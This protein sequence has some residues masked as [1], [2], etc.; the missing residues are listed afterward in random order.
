[1]AQALIHSQSVP[2][3]RRGGRNPS[4]IVLPKA[5][6]LA[7]RTALISGLAL[8]AQFAAPVAFAQTAPSAPAS[9][10]RHYAVPAGPLHSVL[11]SFA[12]SAGLELSVDAHLLQGRTSSGLSGSFTVEQGFAELLR[13]QGLQAVRQANGSYTL[14]KQS[15]PVASGHD[16]SSHDAALAVVTVVGQNANQQDRPRAYAGGQVARGARLG[17][18]GDVSVMDAPFN[19]T[20]YT[21]KL[22]EDQQSKTVNDVLRNDPSVRMTTSDGHNAENI[23]IRGFDVNSSEL[24]FNGMYGMLPGAHTPTD[25]LERVEVFKGPSAMLSGIAPSGAVG[26]V[27]NLVPKRAADEPLTRLTTSYVSASTLG[28]AL[29]VGRRFGED[30]QIGVRVNASSSYG[31]S[32]LEDQDKRERFGSLGLD[33]RGKGWKLEFDAYSA[34]QNQSNGSPLMVGFGTLGHV[35]DAPDPRTNALRGTWAK[36]QSEGMAVRGELDLSRQW[37]L[38]AALG[39]ARYSYDGYLNGTRVVVL[40]DDGSARGQTYNQ[41]GYTHSISTEFGLRGNFE[42]GVVGHKLGISFSSLQTRNGSASV[43]SS[44]SYKTNIYDPTDALLAAEHGATLQTANNRY[45]GVSLSDT[46]SMLDDALL[47]TLGARAQNVKQLQA[48]PVAYDEDALTPVV[49]IVVK[50]WGPSLSLYA[51]YIEG[52]SPGAT[53]GSTY[54]N[55]GETLAPYKTRQSEAGVKWEW[56]SFTN[57]FSLFRIEKPS[58]ISID[59]GAKLPTLAVDGKQRHTGLEWNVFGEIAPQVRLLGGIAYTKAEQLR[60]SVAANDGKDAPGVPRWAANLGTEW[61]TPWIPALTLSTRLIYTGSQYLDAAN[62]LEIPSW[63]RWD[64]GANYAQRVYGKPFTLRAAVE[65]VTD[66]RYWA[67][68]FNDGFATQGAPR[69]YKL[70]ASLDF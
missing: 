13:A 19:V 36:Q 2:R 6:V 68:Y 29:D 38:Y 12:A 11:T 24:A 55:S 35:I 46:L 40:A 31:E 58:S 49:G 37:S 32:M 20:A 10:A 56:H 43:M 21:S 52:L 47:L 39:Q 53:V 61:D 30:K 9:V 63:T 57:T 4:A 45:T 15:E 14:V 65:N 1:M 3:Q 23:R 59:T 64:V 66:E 48:T 51:N 41:A 27:V 33:Y 16:A 60:S 70:S 7:V 18:L 44:A 5:C 8:G 25:F 69:T 22:M 17:V 50:P 26:G 62:K 42:T 28:A 67:G 34:N 54:A